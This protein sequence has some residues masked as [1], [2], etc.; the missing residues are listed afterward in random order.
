MS[1]PKRKKL[2]KDYSYDIVP[3]ELLTRILKP[4]S[5]QQRIGLRAVSTRFQAV[6][7]DDLKDETSLVIRVEDG[8]SRKTTQD[9]VLHLNLWSINLGLIRT[10]KELMPAITELNI[11]I[12]SI[13]ILLHLIGHYDLKKLTLDF[14]WGTRSR[15]EF[16]GDMST[17]AKIINSKQ[18]LTHLSLEGYYC[19]EDHFNEKHLLMELKETL[20]RLESFTFQNAQFDHHEEIEDLLTTSLSTRCT[21]L[22]L[23]EQNIDLYRAQCA[24]SL[25]HLQLE[26]V[27]SFVV[28]EAFS[29]CHALQNL[30]INM[31]SLFSNPPNV[32]IA[33]LSSCSTITNPFSH[34]FS[35]SMIWLWTT[36][37]S[38]CYPS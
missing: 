1:L 6:L 34:S 3:N 35:G 23:T 36:T 31:Q 24:A 21:H 28:W 13:Y 22:A 15:E 14:E 2:K 33:P 26:D 11:N 4:L 19:K 37:T 20:S 7:E 9:D 38:D 16:I 32:L 27:D 25:T 29:Y 10:L 18:D 30:R 17:L 5:L 12:R 8:K